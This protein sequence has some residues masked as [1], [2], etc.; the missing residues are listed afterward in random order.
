M[1]RHRRPEVEPRDRPAVQ[2]LLKAIAGD[3]GKSG[4][5]CD[6]FEANLLRV[7]T[8]VAEEVVAAPRSRAAGRAKRRKSPPRR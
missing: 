2:A 1:P 4:V 5:D 6:T 8:R 3:A 7:L